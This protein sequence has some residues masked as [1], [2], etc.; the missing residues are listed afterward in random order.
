MISEYK[1]YG[2]A[3][4]EVHVILNHT[5]LNDVSKIPLSLIEMIEENED[6]SYEPMIDFTLPLENQNLKQETLNILAIL[7]LNYWCHSQEEKEKM[8]RILARNEE[9]YQEELRKTYN[10]DNL[11]KNK[12]EEK[13]VSTNLPVEVKPPTIFERFLTWLKNL[14]KKEK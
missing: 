3:L 7:Y 12:Q 11:F 10:P 4:K 5:N 14:F 6:T 1:D 13:K 8:Q 2:Q 9:L